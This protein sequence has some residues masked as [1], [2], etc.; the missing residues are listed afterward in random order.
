MDSSDGEAFNGG[1]GYPNQGAPSPR[2]SGFPAAFSTMDLNSVNPW[3][4]MNAYGT[5]ISSG[6]EVN[7]MLALP[8]LRLSSESR[9]TRSAAQEPRS[10]GEGGGTATGAR[11]R[12]PTTPRVRAPGIT[13]SDNFDSTWNPPPPPPRVQIL[14]PQL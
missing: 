14:S 12:T 8:P 4:D 7:A 1:G 11:G 9:G 5:Y 13:S 2:G 10:G 6:Q 3:P